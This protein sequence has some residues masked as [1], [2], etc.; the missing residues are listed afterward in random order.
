MGKY[1]EKNIMKRVMKVLFT[2]FVEEDVMSLQVFYTIVAL[3]LIYVLKDVYGPLS[4][5]ENIL[6]LALHF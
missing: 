1:A 2:Q 3:K 4:I 5:R 6:Y